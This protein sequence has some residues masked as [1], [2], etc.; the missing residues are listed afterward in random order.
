MKK[1]GEETGPKSASSQPRWSGRPGFTF[2]EKVEEKDVVF[3]GGVSLSRTVQHRAG[4]DKKKSVIFEACRCHYWE[5]ES[6]AFGLGGEGRE[7]GIKWA[8]G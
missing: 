1:G 7:R 5:C 6:G 2:K 4:K 3:V 8:H